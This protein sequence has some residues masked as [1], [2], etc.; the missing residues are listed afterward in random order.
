MLGCR[1]RLGPAESA[2]AIMKLSTVA[3]LLLATLP[4]IASVTLTGCEDDCYAGETRCV[5]RNYEQD[6]VPNI[7]GGSD[8]WWH[9]FPCVFGQAC[10]KGSCRCFPGACCDEFGIPTSP[11]GTECGSG[12]VC[13]GGTCVI[14]WLDLTVLVDEYPS[15]YAEILDVC[16]GEGGARW[17]YI[18]SGCSV[19][20]VGQSP[21]TRFI[22]GYAPGT[23]VEIQNFGFLDR[24]IGW[25]G[26]C[27]G[28]AASSCSVII[29]GHVTVVAH[30]M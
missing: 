27:T 2:G 4:L 5:G 14:D 3:V 13:V 1:W 10:T 16:P 25:E 20:A 17:S 7:L 6:C 29:S 28:S 21:A 23:S 22:I 26:A 24:F 12:A 11:D 19:A 9:P 15:L 30:F 18:D 8:L